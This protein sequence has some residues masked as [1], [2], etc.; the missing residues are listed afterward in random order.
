VESENT[1]LTRKLKQRELEQR[2]LK[3]RE[4]NEYRRTTMATAQITP[5]N[6][7]VLAEVLIAAPPERVFQALTDVNQM[8]KWWGQEGVYRI[9]KC[10][11]DLRPGGKWA[12]IGVGRDGSSFSV[13]GEY[14]E[15]DPPRLLVYTWNPSFATLKNT[16]VRCE[17]EAR[18]VHGLQHRGPQ[19]LGTG[20]LVK[21]RHSGFAGNIDAAKNHGEGWKRVFTWLKAY[22][23]TGETTDNRKPE[24][25]VAT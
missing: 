14:L 2:E 25:T 13:E 19:R 16:T 11:A 18:D 10:E 24:A 4:F 9:T 22:A 5:D 1:K 21:I 6:D 7:T 17:L 23:E 12:S 20:T 3:Q 8:P 15:V